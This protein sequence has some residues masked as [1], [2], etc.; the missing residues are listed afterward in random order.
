LHKATLKHALSLMKT[1]T[2]AP[3]L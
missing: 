1:E 2:K 3:I